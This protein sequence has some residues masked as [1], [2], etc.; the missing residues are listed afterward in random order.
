MN[1]NSQFITISDIPVEVVRKSVKNLHLGVYPPEGRVR[2]TV[3]KNITDDN[4]RLAVIS[5]L[6]WIRK[7]QAEFKAQPRQTER[8]YVSGESHYFEGKRYLLD[9]VERQG[10][11][12]VVLTNNSKLVLYV[13]AGTSVDNKARVFNDWYRS[14]LKQ[15]LP[16]LLDKW[17]ARVG[18]TANHIQI[19]RMK[20]RWGSCN[21][22]DKRI[23]LN[24]ELAKKSPE[25][26]EYILVHELIHLHERK[27]NEN[28]MAHL[29]HC[30]PNW[31]HARDVLKSE[32]LA[33]EEWDY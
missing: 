12:E 10:K 27:H 2:V 24:V 31:R 23:L 14:Q 4:V 1:I 30:M 21:I 15:K 32:P 6:T 33:H 20:T 13:K 26:L 7:Q 3:P 5:R 25:C 18:K 28:F 22:E 19:K 16:D 11:H 29:D 17:Q 9:V 8:Q